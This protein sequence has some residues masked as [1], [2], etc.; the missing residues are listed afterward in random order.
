MIVEDKKTSNSDPDGAKFKSWL[1]TKRDAT[2]DDIQSE[3]VQMFDWLLKDLAF[4]LRIGLVCAVFGAGVGAVTFAFLGT[5]WTLGLVPGAGV[6]GFLG[7]V[8]AIGPF[9]R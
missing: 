1:A 2:N 3:T 8:F 4:K 7:F 5:N 9:R 6:L